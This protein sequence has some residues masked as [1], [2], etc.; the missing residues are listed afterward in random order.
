MNE[1]DFTNG[2][3]AYYNPHIN[4]YNAWFEQYELV[5]EDQYGRFFKV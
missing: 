3:V 2:A 4:G 5:Y 1:A